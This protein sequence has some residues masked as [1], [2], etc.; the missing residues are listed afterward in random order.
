MKNRPVRPYP[1]MAAFASLL[2]ACV[3]AFSS[4][5]KPQGRI[6]GLE[7][8]SIL[9]LI[10]TPEKFDGKVVQV[11]GFLRLEFEGNILYL[12]EEDYKRGITKNGLWVTRNAKIN[13]KADQLNIHYVILIGTFDAGHK[14]H[15]S[16]T[17]GTII[18][19]IAA[20]PWPIPPK[21]S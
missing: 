21:K 1:Q 5:S 17:S 2:F 13:E 8:V 4:A 20:D 15:M 12:H 7:Q 3:L 19:I 16:A 11:V 18:N 6:P 14:G 9:Q 10:A